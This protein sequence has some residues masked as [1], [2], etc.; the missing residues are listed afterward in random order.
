MPWSDISSLLI[1]I[2]LACWCFSLMRKNDALKRENNRLLKKTG[3]YE[4]IKSEAKEILSTSTE[5]KAVKSLR[6]KYGLSLVDA[7]KVVDSVK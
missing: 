4:D 5:V 7:K 6:E 3:E 1:I 2:A